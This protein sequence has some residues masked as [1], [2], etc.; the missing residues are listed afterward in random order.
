MRQDVVCMRSV[1]DG[2][3]SYEFVHKYGYIDVI[4]KPNVLYI[5]YCVVRDDKRLRGVGSCLLKALEK[6]SYDL[7][8]D[9]MGCILYDYKLVDQLD[10]GIGLFY[11]KNGYTIETKKDGGLYVFK[12]RATNRNTS[13]CIFVNALDESESSD[14]CQLI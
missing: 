2:I 9:V 3:V 4:V 6:L 11:E 5:Q 7:R 10:N 14:R 1:K 12:Q 13:D 8:L